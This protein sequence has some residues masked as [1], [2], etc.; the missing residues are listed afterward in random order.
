MEFPRSTDEH[1]Y[2]SEINMFKEIGVANFPCI[3]TYL[4]VR[5]KYVQGN[6]RSQFPLHPNIFIRQK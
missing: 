4:F 6:R 5:N 2:S 3:R 1:I